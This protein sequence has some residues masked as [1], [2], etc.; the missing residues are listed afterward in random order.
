MRSLIKVEELARLINSTV[1]PRD[2]A[3]ITLLAKI[4]IHIRELITLGV[5]DIDMITRAI[6]LKPKLKW[7]NRAIFFDD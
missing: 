3:I 7:S 5:K 6:K 2:K 1:G 4:G